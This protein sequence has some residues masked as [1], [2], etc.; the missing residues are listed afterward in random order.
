MNTDYGA[1]FSEKKYKELIAFAKEQQAEQVQVFNLQLQQ[2]VYLTQELAL[3]SGQRAK[4]LGGVA[5]V[6]ESKAEAGD[7]AQTFKALASHSLQEAYL[8]EL[9]ACYSKSKAQEA[10]LKAKAAA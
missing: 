7:I 3:L 1:L 2:L 5:S 4:H 10:E 8:Q 6:E 9:F